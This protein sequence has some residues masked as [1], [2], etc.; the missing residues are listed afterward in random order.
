MAFSPNG[1]YVYVANHTS[2]TISEIDTASL[3]VIRT[4]T[5]QGNP[6]A[7][8]VTNDGDSTDFDETVYVTD[9]FSRTISGKR[10]GFDD[11]KQGVIYYFAIGSSSTNSSTIAPLANSG[12]PA[13]R[14]NFCAETA[15]AGD[16]LQSEIFCPDTSIGADNTAVIQ[17]VYPNQFYS[18][19]V[20]NDK[21]Y[22]P[23]VG[24]ALE[25][26]VKF[27]VNIQALVNVLDTKTQSEITFAAVNLNNLIKTETQPET[28]D[29]SLG[30]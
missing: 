17:G 11:S 2:K 1:T 19:I 18:A 26:P 25:P 6:I 16:N 3:T 7:V 24:A 12:F 13:D 22:L 15:A 30:N 27:N 23:N 4:L 8:A 14:S 21:L 5:V 29:G 9:F 28:T 10:D 20:R